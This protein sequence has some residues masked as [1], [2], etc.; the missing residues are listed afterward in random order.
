MSPPRTAPAR[1]RA[2]GRAA[3]ASARPGH[4]T[5]GRRSAG[6]AGPWQAGVPDRVLALGAG[7]LFALAWGLLL[8]LAA[9]LAGPTRAGAQPPG[10][11]PWPP[12]LHHVFPTHRGRLGIEIQ[13]LTPELRAFMEAPEDRGL[14]VAKVEPGR[15]G[16]KAGLR[17]GDVLVAAGDAPLRRPYDLVRRLARVPAGESIALGVVR[18]GESLTVSAAPEGEATP[19]VDPEQWGDWIDRGMSEGSEQLREKL[20]DLER[21]LEE[22]ERKLEDPDAPGQAT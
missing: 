10:D 21:R 18:K 19:W 9:G 13:T 20:R 11:E 8:A 6:A 7:L 15:A 1:P 12:G 22:L 16:E 2:P 4:P 5:P 3:D 14:L 17:V